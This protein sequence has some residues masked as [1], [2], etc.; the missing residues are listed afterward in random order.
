MTERYPHTMLYLCLDLSGPDVPGG[1]SENDQS[2]Q[3]LLNSS[4]PTGPVRPTAQVLPVQ[5]DPAV[6]L[7]PSSPFSLTQSSYQPQS[8]DSQ[9][10]LS[11]LSNPA[12]ILTGYRKSWAPQLSSAD[13][14][15]KLQAPSVCGGGAGFSG[16]V[17][18]GVGV[19]MRQE[20]LFSRLNMDRSVS[21]QDSLLCQGFS[22]TAVGLMVETSSAMTSTS[23]SLHH[24]SHPPLHFHLS[25]SS[26]LSPSGYYSCLPISIS[27]HPSSSGS[28]GVPV[29]AVSG[30]SY[31]PRPPTS[32]VPPSSAP[33]LHQSPAQTS[34]ACA[35]TSCECQESCGQRGTLPGYAMS[36]YL[37]PLSADRSLFSLGPLV[38]LSPLIA[39][40]NSGATSFS[41]PIMVPSPIYRHS[42]VSP[43]QHQGFA[44]YQPHGVIGNGSQKRAVGSLSCYNCGSSGHKA[45]A[46]KQPTMEPA[47]QGLFVFTVL[48]L[49]LNLPYLF[50]FNSFQYMTDPS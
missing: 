45:E 4:C 28:A 3:F 17:S 20:N 8:R 40:S 46:C 21:F 26:S 34:S 49:C 42:A 16:G 30:N 19:G 7:S 22:R 11:S 48:F 32:S 31:Q 35:C 41:Y 12:H 36:G 44:F 13:D 10:P 23:N 2:C 50:S 6:P 37:Q 25:S 27:F 18:G 1:G 15:V 14:R 43:D 39:A 47:Q 24:V 9:C 29:A 5:T 38:H 33:S